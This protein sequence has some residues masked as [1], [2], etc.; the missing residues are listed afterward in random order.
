MKEENV[1]YK[2][3]RAHCAYKHTEQTATH[4]CL[5]KIKG[6][7][8]LAGLMNLEGMETVP[9]RRRLISLMYKELYEKNR[10]AVARE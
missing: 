10:M 8:Q 3:A 5:L 2:Q 4:H 7:L 1:V 6:I 9:R